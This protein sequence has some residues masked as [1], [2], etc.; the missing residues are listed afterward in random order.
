M[1]WYDPQCIY[2]CSQDSS[3]THIH[4]LGLPISNTSKATISELLLKLTDN[5]CKYFLKSSPTTHLWRH[6]GKRIYSS[7][8]CLTSAI[9]GGEWSA[10]RSGRALSLVP[11]G[12]EV[13]WAPEPVW[14]QRLEEK[15]S[16]LCW[17]SNLDRPVHSQTLCWL[18]YPSSPKY[19]LLWQKWRLM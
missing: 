5:L 1:S 6:T 19:F 7:Y 3:K 12:E 13:G 11:I 8:S 14:I 17:R 18:S 4:C 2:I 16:C 15:S 10:S 9:H